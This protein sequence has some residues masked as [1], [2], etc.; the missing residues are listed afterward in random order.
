MNTFH[1]SFLRRIALACILISAL[2][3]LVGLLVEMVKM[4][5]LAESVAREEAARLIA[6]SK[7]SDPPP[8]EALDEWHDIARR[9]LTGNGLLLRVY[10]PQGDLTLE[11]C[12]PATVPLVGRLRAEL[13]P[14]ERNRRAGMHRFVL[15]G[16]AMV[17][18]RQ[19]LT[20]VNGRPT[21]MLDAVYLLDPKVVALLKGYIQRISLA[22]LLSTLASGAVLY[23]LLHSLHRRAMGF[24][25]DLTSANL[26]LAS[27]LGSAIAQRDSGTGTHNFRVTLYAI[28][29]GLEVKEPALDMRTLILGAFLHDVGK[30][31]IHDAILLKPGPLTAEERVVMC[32]HVERGVAIIESSNWLHLA[33]NVIECH[34]ERFDGKGY[35]RGIEGRKIPLEARIFAIVD[36]FDALTSERPYKP[37]IPLPEVLAILDREAGSHFDPDLVVLFHSIAAKAFR[38]IGG[39]AEFELQARLKAWVDQHRSFLHTDRSVT[40]KSLAGP[41]VPGP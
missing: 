22:A 4:D 23:P 16:R 3:G 11:S 20:D 7:G 28:Q 24:S 33:R 1:R 39:A 35:P 9:T 40:W 29:L 8:P 34:H 27:V 32:S 12:A 6:R 13:M 5:R 14:L 21:G 17:Q 36:A 41:F 2:V 31:G 37:A 38:D 15:D 19:P 18:V 30:I 10:G 25:E 26:E